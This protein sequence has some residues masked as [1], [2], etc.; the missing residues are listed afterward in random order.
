MATETT[1]ID[2]RWIELLTHMLGAGSH[3]KKSQ[4]G[5]R[6]RFAA[7]VDGEHY[8]DMLA[9]QEAGL[10]EAGPTINRG[11]MQLFGATLA[12]CQAAGLS[13]AATKRALE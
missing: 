5:Y 12:G 7:E 1:T 4:H 13:K 9:M 3:V 8:K 10:V 6:N 2:P 11:T